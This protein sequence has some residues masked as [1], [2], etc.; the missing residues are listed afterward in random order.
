[1]L[2]L[3]VLRA[4]HLLVELA[5]ARLGYRFEEGPPFRY[6]PPGDPLGEEVPQLCLCRRL[7]LPE[8]D[9]R[10]WTLAPA[11]VGYPHHGGFES[12]R[13]CHEVVL[14]LDRGDP[15]ATGLDDVL[16]PVGERDV[17]VAGQRAHVAGTQP[18]VVELG[19]VGRLVA[20]VRGG[21]PGSAHFELADGLPVGGR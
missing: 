7:S 2:T 11:V 13:V 20:E 16:G 19:R 6:L 3:G 8:Y 14:Q 9:C 17:P 10:K 21:N 18:A 5:H 4:D 1:D 12:R 15:L